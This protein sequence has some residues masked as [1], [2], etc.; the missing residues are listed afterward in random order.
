MFLKNKKGGKF[1]I[2]KYR[3]KFQNWL[4]NFCKL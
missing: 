1:Y 4:N 2:N 3:G